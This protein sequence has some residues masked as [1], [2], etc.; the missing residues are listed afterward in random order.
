MES[1]PVLVGN[2]DVKAHW[3]D[4][5]EKYTLPMFR[6]DSRERERERADDGNGTRRLR[7]AIRLVFTEFNHTFKHTYRFFFDFA[8]ADRT[9]AA[10]L[11]AFVVLSRKSICMDLQGMADRAAAAG[12][13]MITLRSS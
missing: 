9:L 2:S 10:A 5:K 4:K 11:D 1:E 6:G 3:V 7:L 8:L 12:D 13:P